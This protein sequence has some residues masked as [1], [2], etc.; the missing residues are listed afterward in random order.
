MNHLDEYQGFRDREILEPVSGVQPETV[1]ILTFDDE[2]SLR[3]WLES[4]ALEQL[5]ARLDPHIEGTYT[6]NVLGGF[7]GWFSFDDV[8]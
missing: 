8:A 1:V 3:R 2:L 5:L 6:T 7:A 4:E